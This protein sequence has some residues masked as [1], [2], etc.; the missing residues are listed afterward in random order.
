MR[1]ERIH[2]WLQQAAHPSD[3]PIF[4]E[5][6][7]KIPRLLTIIMSIVLLAVLLGVGYIVTRP[8]GPALTSAEFGAAVISPNADG[9]TDATTLTYEVSRDAKVSTYFE[10]SAGQ[11]FYFRRE[12]TRTHGKYSVLFSGIVEG[13][14]RA[15]E[16][17]KGEVLSR[18]LENGAYTWTVEALDLASGS[19]S[20]LSGSISIQ[21]AD[22]TLP[23]LWEFSIS[24]QEFT[25]NQDGLTDR[26]YINVYVPKPAQLTV[27][28]IDPQGVHY[29]I[30]EANEVR[31]PGDEGR[32]SFEY[33]GGIDAGLSP[34]PDGE[35][36]VLVEAH[37]Q[38]GQFVRTSGQLTIKNGGLPLAEISA[39]PVGDTVKFNSET[40]IQGDLLT[41]ELT[42]ENY[43]DAPIRTTGPPSGFVYDQNQIFSSTGFYEESGAWR[44]GIHCD[45]CLTDYPWRWALGTPESL[46]L[47]TASDGKVHY[48]LMPGQRAVVTGSIRLVNIT[49][50]R[51][52]QQFWAGLIHE[53]V[54]ISILNNRVDPH[55]IEIVPSALFEA[56][57]IP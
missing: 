30:P 45:T 6:G 8:I 17:I 51:N 25:P 42:V 11:R 38:E 35:Y 13:Y 12:E 14:A 23:D 16:S 31:K 19:L 56:T 28:L 29:F 21:D 46:T 36:T 15:G 7:V 57:P 4:L 55:W 41:F 54:G 27:Y 44:V 50:S 9:L 24:P 37:D 20:T 10:N 40:I 43:G 2:P 48:Y 53:D 5:N 22:A 39:Q 52:P 47:I 32:H 34:P 1:S 33:D 3:D 26:V 18:L 49:P